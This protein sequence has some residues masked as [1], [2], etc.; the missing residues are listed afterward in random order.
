[1]AIRGWSSLVSS[2]MNLELR[3]VVLPGPSSL[4]WRRWK[5]DEASL[6]TCFM[7]TSEKLKCLLDWCSDAARIFSFQMLLQV[8]LECSSYG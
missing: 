6:P 5:R 7:Y 4:E 2:L 1:M 8:L 3:G